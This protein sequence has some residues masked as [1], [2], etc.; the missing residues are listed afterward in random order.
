MKTVLFNLLKISTFTLVFCTSNAHSQVVD[1]PCGSDHKNDSLF[2]HD[3]RFS[4]SMFLL[5][6][7]IHQNQQLSAEDRTN[8]IYTLPVV[9]HVIHEGEPI[10]QGSNISDEQILS[11]INALNEDFRKLPGTNGF[12]DGVD[13]GIQFCLA[14]RNPS[15]QPTTGIVRVNGSSVPLYAEQGIQS[16]GGNGANELA[17]K[18]LSTWPRTSYVNIWVVNEIGNN[19]GGSGVQGYAYFPVANPIDGIVVL[20][21]AFGTVGNLKSYTNLNRTL[22]HEVGH[23]LGLYHT[24]HDTNTCAESNCTTGG[25]RVCDTPPTTINASCSMPACSGTQQVENYLDYTSQTCQNM[26]TDGQ[27][28][29]MR[30]TLESQRTSM[31]SS[32]GCMPVYTRDA[33]IT[34]VAAPFGTSCNTSYIPQVTLTNFGSAT[35][36]SCTINYNLNGSGNNTFSWTGNLASGSSTNVTLPTITAA[37]GSYTFYAFT[38]S[39]NGQ[40]DEN[41]SNNQSTSSFN[42]T[43]GATFTLTVIVDFFGAE[44]TWEVRDANNNLMD[45]G[46]P[47]PNNVQGTAF[48]ESLCLPNGC[49]SLNFF[50][51]YGDGQSFTNGSFTLRDENNVVLFTR[52]GNWGPMSANPFCVTTAPAGSA[53]SANFTVNDNL[54]CPNGSVNFTY[55]GQNNP[56]TYSWIFEGASTAVS[57]AA[58]PSGIQYL[59][60]GVYDVTLTV[61]NEFGSDSY[62]CENC[63][64][65]SSLPAIAFNITNPTCFG[66]NNGAITTAVSNGNA[67]YTYN[68]TNGPTSANRTSLAS[69]SYTLNV[70]DAQGCTAQSTATLSQPSSISI[71]GSVTNATCSGSANG[72]IVASAN[73]GTGAIN[74]VWSNGQTGSI[75]NNL[76]A[77]SYT[78]VATD[79]NNCSAS[80]VFNVNAPAPLQVSVFHTDATCFGMTDGSAVASATG[81]TGTINFIWSTGDNGQFISNA[82]AGTYIVTAT[83]ANGCTDTESFLIE[84]PDMLVASAIVLS[85]ETCAGNDGSATV[86]VEGGNGDYLIV[87]A[88]GTVQSTIENTSAGN[89]LVSIADMNGCTLNLQVNIPYECDADIAQ[90]RLVD[91][92]CGASNMPL[93]S[94]ISCVPVEN[95]SMYQWKFATPTGAIITEEFTLSN[96]FFLAQSNAITNNMNLLISV[97]AMVESNWGEYG[98]VCSFQTEQVLGTTALS[99]EDCGSTITTW[100]TEITA[101]VIENALLY[102]WEITTPQGIIV[103]STLDNTLAVNESIGIQNNAE[104]SIRVRAQLNET[105]FTEWGNAC[106]IQIAIETI[107]ID[108]LSNTAFQIYPNPNDGYQITIQ[109]RGEFSIGSISEI[110]IFNGAGQIVELIIP[111]E[112]SAQQSKVD[113]IFQNKLSSGLYFLQYRIGNVQLEEKLIVR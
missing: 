92:D 11:A 48:T 86:N 17:V 59:N 88:D 108:E 61:S 69:G 60:P 95:A 85:P 98:E 50:D 9:V 77:G 18:S 38:S 106:N 89:Y 109:S 14:S 58:N 104:Y 62:T 27:K 28:V 107:D 65:V 20:H 72:Q 44:N 113:F 31:L 100:N 84:Q 73:G 53:P 13:V 12:G 34:A 6:S 39:P 83:D 3:P 16:S 52:S 21:N 25:D 5:E 70:T 40:T 30:T 64:T 105:T 46:G 54:I 87:W 8:E 35:L 10:G 7:V 55:T 82:A 90:T 93:T 51:S 29:R 15:G 96:Q 23:Y 94:I 63:I 33:G 74:L 67:P 22:T 47:Y 45:F 97:K 56:S 81:G 102:E 57:S 75:S 37:V 1:A 103:T 36:T 91:A 112:Q 4:R 68:W 78:V 101:N 43:N 24:F 99:E 111:Q 42:V 80:Q 49:Y 26:F 76:G 71:A 41:T 110:K 19:D 79:A 32:L 66:G 2:Q